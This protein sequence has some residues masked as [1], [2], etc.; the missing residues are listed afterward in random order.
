MCSASSARRH[1]SASSATINN[2]RKQR[3]KLKKEWLRRR[4]SPRPLPRRCGHS[5]APLKQRAPT[6]CLR[7]SGAPPTRSSRRS[8]RSEGLV[9]ALVGRGL[10]REARERQRGGGFNLGGKKRARST[11]PL[12]LFGCLSG[13]LSSASRHPRASTNPGTRTLSLSLSF[14]SSSF[15]LSLVLLLLALSLAKKTRARILACF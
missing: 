7:C 4:P 13:F 2:K 14:T 1:P 8:S 6:T 3:L 5:S 15:L 11:L 12:S 10:E 9:W